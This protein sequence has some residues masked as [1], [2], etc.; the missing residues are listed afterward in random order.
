MESQTNVTKLKIWTRGLPRWALNA[1]NCI[2][3]KG[4]RQVSH[5]PGKVGTLPGQVK[6]GGGRIENADL[7]GQEHPLPAGTEQMLPHG[8]LRASQGAQHS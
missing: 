7:A 3:I 8:L 4:R 6:V 5:L 2:F 1:V